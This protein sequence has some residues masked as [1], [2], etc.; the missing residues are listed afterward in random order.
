MKWALW[1]S[2]QAIA[3][4]RRIDRS[5]VGNVTSALDLLANN[6]TTVNL[7]PNEDDPS[8]YW[9]AVEGD[10]TIHFEILDERHAIRV[11]EIE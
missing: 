4:L 10:D 1:L 8:R 3:A 2:P 11:I 5:L 9:I 6:P 7:Q